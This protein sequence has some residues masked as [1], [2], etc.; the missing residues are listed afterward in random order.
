MP[1]APSAP[2]RPD[3]QVQERASRRRFTAAYKTRILKEADACTKPGELGAL[4]RR[5]GLYSSTLANFRKL[6]EAGKLG[7]KNPAQAH[8]SA[9][10]KKPPANATPA[11]LAA[12]WKP[13]TRNCASCWNSKKKWRPCSTSRWPRPERISLIARKRAQ[14]PASDAP[15]LRRRLQP[16]PLLSGAT[17]PHE[18]SAR[19]RP[20]LQSTTGFSAPPF[21]RGTRPSAQPAAVGTLC[22]RFAATGVCATA[23]R[24]RVSRFLSHDVPP[25]ARTSGRV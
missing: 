17:C 14:R 12:L 7:E 2:L 23:A 15:V 3:P 11:A 18:D 20:S 22:G 1:A 19:T 16:R 25:V 21:G 8:S 6:R 24:R 4:L 10:T 5:E 9:K 13:K